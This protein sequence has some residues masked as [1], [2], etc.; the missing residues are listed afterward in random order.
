MLTI[1]N[2]IAHNVAVASLT[3]NDGE[4]VAVTGP[5]GS[6][7]TLLLRAICDLDV[8]T[9]TIMLGDLRRDAV[10]A[11]EWRRR[12]A[13]VPAESGWWA[14]TVGDHFTGAAETTDN[15]M[16]LGLSPQVMTWPVARL[17]SGERQ[18]LALVR[19]LENSPDILLLDEP[20]SSLD[21][22]SAKAVETLIADHCKFG[23]SALLVSHDAQQVRRLAR[24]SLRLPTGEITGTDFDSGVYI[25]DLAE[26]TGMIE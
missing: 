4:C 7:K 3:V 24:R 6:G 9:G 13:M 8:S 15:L 5:S 25:G 22:T 19:A 26:D 10:P 1:Q 21:A 23:A 12:V 16:T 18:R 17:S 11:P 2:L 14:D 20:T